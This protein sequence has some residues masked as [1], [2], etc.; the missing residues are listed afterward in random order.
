MKISSKVDLPVLLGLTIA[1][2][3][4]WCRSKVARLHG[5]GQGVRCSPCLWKVKCSTKYP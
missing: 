4:H 3:S 5:L 2:T 1:K